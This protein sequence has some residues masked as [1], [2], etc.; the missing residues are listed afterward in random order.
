MYYITELLK[1][2]LRM[3]KKKL[4]KKKK[5]KKKKHFWFPTRFDTN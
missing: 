3:K 2:S 4:K 5:K 1:M